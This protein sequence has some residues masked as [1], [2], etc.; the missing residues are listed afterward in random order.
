MLSLCR[1]ID[2]GWVELP[3]VTVNFAEH[4]FC[5]VLGDVTDSLDDSCLD[6]DIVS[7]DCSLEVSFIREDIISVS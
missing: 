1:V 7:T 2:S 5:S 6:V 4:C 3:D